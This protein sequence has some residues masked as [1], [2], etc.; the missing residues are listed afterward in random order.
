MDLFRDQESAVFVQGLH[1]GG[2]AI[3]V[4]RSSLH[5]GSTL[6]DRS[7]L[8]PELAYRNRE[9]SS[10][11]ST[12]R[13][14][15]NKAPGKDMAPKHIV[16]DSLSVNAAMYAFGAWCGLI[17]RECASAGGL[18]RPRIRRFSLGLTGRWL[19]QSFGL[20][21]LA[22]RRSPLLGSP[23]SPGSPPGRVSCF[24]GFVASLSFMRPSL[25][26]G[27]AFP[28]QGRWPPWFEPKSV[29]FRDSALSFGMEA[30]F[31]GS[32]ALF[33]CPPAARRAGAGSGAQ[34]RADGR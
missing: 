12:L 21:D 33:C 19:A 4:V 26:A 29:D 2:N 27:F 31:E 25:A 9:A 24:E 15:I 20:P 30:P 16:L 13:K 28:L 22:F 18:A 7:V 17:K 3:A 14:A 1:C 8:R 32:L 10:A 6:V 11:M 5:L 23:S 34:A